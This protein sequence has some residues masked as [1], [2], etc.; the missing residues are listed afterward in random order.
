MEPVNL[1]PSSGYGG[2]ESVMRKTGRCNMSHQ[3][4]DGQMQTGGR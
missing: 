3:Y 1:D 2:Y 4:R